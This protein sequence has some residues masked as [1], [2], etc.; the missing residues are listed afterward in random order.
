[1]LGISIYFQDFDLEYLK[2]AKECGAKY[3]FT[4]LHIPEEDYSTLDEKLSKLLDACKAYDIALVPDISPVTFEKLKV[5]KNDYAALKKMGFTA[6]RLDYGFDDFEVVKTL[7]KDFY[8]MLNASVIN[9]QYLQQ[10]KEAGV[11]LDKIALT[12]NFYP[13]SNTGLD[14][15]YFKKK[16]E[17]FLAFGCTIQVFVCGDALKRFPLY[18]GLPTVEKHRT[19]HPYVAA[20]ELIHDCGIKDVFIGDSKAKISTLKAIS[21]YMEHKVMRIQCHLEPGYEYLYDTELK[22]RRDIA[23]SIIRVNRPRVQGIPV[24]HN[25][26]RP[27][28]CIVMENQLSGRYSGEVYL[29]KKDLPFEA[30]SNVI[31]Y[32]HPEYIDILDFVD[33]ETTILLEKLTD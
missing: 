26:V 12:H 3:V 18:E 4:S 20:V 22:V 31:G 16:N 23:E 7:Q 9:K 25:T 32:I 6:L 5:E 14:L 27:R 29:V 15:D 33:G 21:E 1:M 10:A 11:D 8:L 17:D 19:M 24:Y 2:Q 28:G 30:R 13:H